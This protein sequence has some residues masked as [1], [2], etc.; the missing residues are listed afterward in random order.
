MANINL[1]STTDNTGSSASIS[2]RLAHLIARLLALV[3]LAVFAYYGYLQYSARS[4]AKDLKEVKDKTTQAQ[5]DALGNKDRLELITRQGQ[6]QNLDKLIKGHVSWS[7]LLP[8]LARVS[9]RSASYASVEAAS[10][11]KMI[12]TVSLPDYREVDKYLQ[13]FDLPEYNEQF[14]DVKVMSITKAQQGT[15]LV[16]QLKIQLTFNPEFLKNHFQ[17]VSATIPASTAPVTIPTIP[18]QNP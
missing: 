5:R 4:T 12:L 7:Y 16:T 6:M 10:S 2:R 8:E 13:I 3:L 14:S 15:V 9:L 18:L 1:L 17:T 11:G